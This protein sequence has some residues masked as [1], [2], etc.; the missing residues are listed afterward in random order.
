MSG[1]AGGKRDLRGEEHGSCNVVTAVEV[2]AKKNVVD[3]DKDLAK[4]VLDAM[5][6]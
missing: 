5:M 3:Y 2:T 1:N 6:K 4:R